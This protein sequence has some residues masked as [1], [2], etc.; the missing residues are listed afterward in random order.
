MRDGDRPDEERP[1]S[2]QSPLRLLLLV[3]LFA[4]AG[5]IL[6]MLALQR[7][8][9]LTPLGGAVLDAA[10]LA[11][12]ITPAL[13][14][15][16]Y[17]PL[18][19]GLR[20]TAASEQSLRKFGA[21]VN[22]SQEAVV[23]TNAAGTIEYVNPAF[24]TITGYTFAEA[25][26]NT[27]RML[28]SGV[29]SEAFYRNLWETIAAG[30]VWS[31][32][33]VNLNK[34]GALYEEEM[35]ITPLV[36]EKGRV[37]HFVGAKRDVTNEKALERRI[38]QAQKLE[39]IGVMTG[40]IAHDFNNILSAIIGYSEMALEETPKEAEAYLDLLEALRASHRARDLIRQLLTFARQGESEMRALKLSSVVKES[41]KLMRATLPANV[42]IIQ[43]INGSGGSVNGDPTKIN[44]IIMNLCANAA[45]AMPDGGAIT[46]RLRTVELESPLVTVQGSVPPGVYQR[47]TVQDTGHGMNPAT[48][49]Q[50]FDPFYTTKEVGRGT[51]LGLA[52]VLSIV[53]A[54]GGGVTVVSSPG[55]GATFDIYLPLLVEEA[56]EEV[57]AELA[58]GPKGSE[59]V[60]FI[61]D[62]APLAR[63][64]DKGLSRL[65]Y[66]VRIFTTAADG[67]AAF[68]EAPAAVDVLVTDLSM[69]QISGAE[70]L[71]Q[72]RAVRPD[73]PVIILTGFGETFTREEAL[74]A[75][76]NAYLYKPVAI[77]ELA[78]AI[79][80]VA[81]GAKAQPP[82]NP[83]AGKT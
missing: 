81:D 72:S 52:A 60:F 44:Q 29:H 63:M 24:E 16:S 78:R 43:D 6:I 25:V 82:L 11:L 48:L 50:I 68:K 56:R 75:G 74:R 23:I 38:L 66:A 65:G 3:A 19:E 61:D 55:A 12:F 13:Y 10:L 33:I 4:V 26:G 67:L 1:P 51:G 14:F 7:L 64:V 9:S 59:R 22:Q 49:R 53:T 39:A 21:F 15:F 8:P 83:S 41:V 31:G 30:Q 5:E 57:G 27:P 28:Q 18:Q 77:H 76:V 80:E 17:R 35:V 54:H 42:E 69:P 40:G 20:R 58:A 79:R 2:G 37:T 34:S 73:L 70:I 71:R 47:L 36:D 46:V 45:H 32:A 62:E